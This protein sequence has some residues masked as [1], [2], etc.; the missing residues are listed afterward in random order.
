[1]NK[2]GKVLVANRGEI[3]V[4]VIRT[5]REMD[6]GSVAVFSEVDR[7]A[8]HVRLAD[9][10]YPIGEA[11]PQKS[12]L[13]IAKIVEV[14]QRAQVDALHS[15]Y[16]F[17]S[18]NADFARACVAQNVRWIGPSPES[19][20]AVGSKTAA[21]ERMKAAGIPVV[22][23]AHPQNAEEL[24]EAATTLGFPVLLKAA[25]G[26]GG[27]GMRVVHRA[28]DLLGA[29][30]RARSEA[31]NA[32]A[33]GEVYVEKVVQ[34]AKH[35]EVQILGDNHGARVHLFERDCSIQRRHQKIIEETPTPSS[36]L[37]T[38]QREELYKT[39][40]RAAA[41]VDYVSAGTVEFLVD[42]AGNFYFLEMNTR[43]QVEHP[44]TELVTGLDLI[45]EQIRIAQGEALGYTQTDVVRRGHAIECRLCAENPRLNFAPSPGTL[46]HLH[47][48]AG[49]FV[50]VDAGVIEGSEVSSF[51]DPMIAKLC[52]WAP[53][54]TLALTRMSR[55][56]SECRIQGVDS[57]RELLYNLIHHGEFVQGD[58]DIHF[59]DERHP[60][61]ELTHSD[62]DAATLAA[63]AASIV[64]H[65]KTS[66]AAES[67]AVL[68]TEPSAWKR[69]FQHAQIP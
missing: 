25:K 4:R 60:V 67:N 7:T 52:V 58:Y 35:I 49:P 11:T 33:D 43:I 32:F 23:G 21:R 10:A 64:Q 62:V 46:S 61:Q 28:E 44:I 17:L 26:G 29:L 1:M 53:S 42:T 55:A 9:E 16:G 69:A 56:L 8:L 14:A 66:L 40:L 36:W 65:E 39:A 15:G 30:E 68:P 19:I 27:K 22:P 47:L 18:E 59:L 20:V 41:A 37:S 54:R 31:Q 50:R 3:A 63:A 5:L 2:F 51:Y 6:I 12:Y 34:P 13:D 38:A 48:A 57:N 24:M 45:R